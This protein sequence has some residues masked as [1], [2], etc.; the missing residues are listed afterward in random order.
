M[1]EL[2]LRRYAMLK[3]H[4][5]L[6]PDEYEVCNYIKNPTA[7]PYID[8]GIKGDL[9]TEVYI[10]FMAV[11]T[12]SAVGYARVIG[13]VEDTTKACLVAFPSTN[14]GTQA[15]TRFGDKSVAVYR[16]DYPYQTRYKATLNKDKLIV[17]GVEVG[18]VGADTE[19]ETPNNLTI[20][21]VNA[22]N[23]TGEIKV[24]GATIK[25]NGNEVCNLVP[26]VRKADSEPGFWDTVRRIFLT[27][28]GEGSLFGGYDA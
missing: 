19:F 13:D 3:K 24:Y 17:D 23:R 27:N 11:S 28:Q 10:D 18:A 7:G 22:T 12:L 26:C 4:G 25:K 1:S 16:A 6:I 5:G 14:S 2:M 21:W 9:N 8:T 15:T 20:F